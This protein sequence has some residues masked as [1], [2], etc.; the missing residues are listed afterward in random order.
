MHFRHSD[1]VRAAFPELAA[2]ALTAGAPTAPV[3]DRLAELHTRAKARLADAPLSALPEIGAWRRAFSRMGLKP[4]QYRCAS[5]SLLRRFAKEGTLPRIHP[6]VD[7][8]NAVSMAY[9]IPVA[10][11]DLDRIDGDLEVRPAGGGE[12]YVP[13][14]GGSE[15]P[16]PGEIVF[17]D[18]GGNAHARRWTNRQSGLSAV[19]PGTGRVLIVAEAMHDGAAADVAALLRTL[20]ADLDALG[21]APS[22]P[23][24]LT[25]DAPGFTC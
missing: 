8:C 6:L 2:G 5:E 4:T 13:L 24:L 22:R 3:D 11:L 7:L 16:A 15:H 17:A 18:A 9:A 20:A 25:R 23:A 12:V 19:R 1:D 14:S 10:A 21:A